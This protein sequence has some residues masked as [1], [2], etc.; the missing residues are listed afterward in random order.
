[1]LRELRALHEAGIINKDAPKCLFPET[2]I[3]NEGWLLRLV[4]KEWLA[5][6]GSPGFG[7]LPFPQGVTAY[8][9][10]QL[11]TPFKARFRADKLAESHTH[12]DGIVGDFSIDG[13]KSGIEL[14]SGF[15]YIAAFEAKLYAPIAQ[16]VTNARWYDQVSRTAACLIN[17]ILRAKPEGSYAAH[18]AVLYPEDNHHIDRTLYTKDYVERQIG[19]RL[20]GFLETG[21][22]GEAVERFARGW[23]DVLQRL[24]VWFLTWED[25][26][27]DIGSDQLRGFYDRSKEFAGLIEAAD[28]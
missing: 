11:Y 26:L 27:E 15:R 10:G 28:S 22:P 6:S 4:L 12:V 13:T 8:S 16:G 14:K 2:L 1:M 25:V 18:L 17:S 19:R 3:F 24:H 7:F 5:G 23:R 21:K 9:E 20:E